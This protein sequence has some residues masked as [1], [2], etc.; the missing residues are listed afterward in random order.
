MVIAGCGGHGREIFAIIHAINAASPDGQ[1][2]RT[3]GFVDDKPSEP[4]LQR[5]RRLGAP[6]LGPLDWLR[7]VS[8]TT[9]IAIGIGDP[10][11][12]RAVG[13][14]IGTYDLPIAGLVH[15]A[16]T[17]GRDLVAGEGVV[18]FAGARITTNVHL[19]CHVHINQNATV[20]HD[21]VIEDYV[22]I[23]PLASVSGDCHLGA[24]VLIGTCASVLQG[25]RI[26][27]DATVGAGA[28]VVRDVPPGVVVKGVPAR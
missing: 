12:R 2:W 3:I 14:R 20:G 13:Q 18:V 22:S 28:C 25:R 21:C 19:G 4:N 23:N 1:A 10:R 27:S 6:Y 11:A 8:H 16:A 15:P 9:Y 26:G 7:G 24:G 5:L 17:V